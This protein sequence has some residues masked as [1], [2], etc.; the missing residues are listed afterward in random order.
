MKKFDLDGPK[1]WIDSREKN[2]KMLQNF[3]GATVTLW[4]GILT[5]GRTPIW[6]ISTKM[7]SVK[8]IELLDD[9]L[10]NFWD[11]NLNWIFLK[12]NAA[13]HKSFLSPRNIQVLAD[14]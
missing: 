14:M 11:F 5:T 12:D 1:Y 13:I 9:V 8:Y 2:Q 6:F 4:A 7:N 10:I 3:G